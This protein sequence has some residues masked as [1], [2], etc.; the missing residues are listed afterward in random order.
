MV[1]IQTHT[2]TYKHTY[3]DT[4]HTVTHTQTHLTLTHTAKITQTHTCTNAHTQ[5]YTH[6]TLTHTHLHIHTYTYTLTHTF[7]HTHT[8]ITST[9]M[10]SHTDTHTLTDTLASCAENV[11]HQLK[12]S[13]KVFQNKNSW[14]YNYAAFR[15]LPYDDQMK[16]NFGETYNRYRAEKVERRDVDSLPLPFSRFDFLIYYST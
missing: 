4:H 16:H 9:R 12:P 11:G 2:Q 10:H 1:S 7:K 3:T 8:H 5:T 13:E 15:R 6:H 14:P